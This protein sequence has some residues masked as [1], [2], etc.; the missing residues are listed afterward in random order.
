[1][2]IKL[3]ETPTLYVIIIEMIKD[4]NN[5]MISIITRNL[6]ETQT[7]R[8]YDIISSLILFM[9]NQI[10]DIQIYFVLGTGT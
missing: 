7:I 10:E 9:K 1:M 3:L 2:V 5:G 4:V 6:Q 8:T